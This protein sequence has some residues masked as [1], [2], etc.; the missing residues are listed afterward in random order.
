MNCE[1]QSLN[2][3]LVFWNSFITHFFTICVGVILWNLFRICVSRYQVTKQSFRILNLYE[4]CSF[5]WVAL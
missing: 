3:L 5:W 1:D 4:W 2:V